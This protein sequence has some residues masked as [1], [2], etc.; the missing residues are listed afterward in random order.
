[1]ALQQQQQQQGGAPAAADGTVMLQRYQQHLQDELEAF[2][3]SENMR[4]IKQVRMQAV[5]LQSGSVLTW[6]TYACQPVC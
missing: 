1:M 6:S 4:P 5:V 3:A 2:E